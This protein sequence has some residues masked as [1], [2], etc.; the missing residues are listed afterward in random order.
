[1]KEIDKFHKKFENFNNIA[2]PIQM[3]DTV[4]IKSEI[5]VVT[6]AFF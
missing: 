4:K 1:M 3:V 2:M 5:D 6:L